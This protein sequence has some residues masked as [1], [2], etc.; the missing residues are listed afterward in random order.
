MTIIDN[1]IYKL[2]AI[3]IRGSMVAGLRPSQ[4]SQ[5]LI[6][7]TSTTSGVGPCCYGV[8]E[9]SMLS[10]LLFLIDMANIID[11]L[12]EGVLRG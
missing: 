9:G 12:E 11:V 3:G 1:L 10:H 4:I 6:L 2:V 8:P 5:I 7:W